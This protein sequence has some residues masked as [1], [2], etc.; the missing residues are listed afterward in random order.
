MASATIEPPEPIPK[1]IPR[2]SLT[3]TIEP[4][5]TVPSQQTRVLLERTTSTST[6]APE[7]AQFTGFKGRIR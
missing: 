3:A 1:Y 5:D 2:T 4:G 7:L 6:L